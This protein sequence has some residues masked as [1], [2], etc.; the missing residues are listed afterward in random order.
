MDARISSKSL[1]KTKRHKLSVA[2][3]GKNILVNNL[4]NWVRHNYLLKH[5]GGNGLFIHFVRVEINVRGHA[6]LGK[7]SV[8]SG[9]FAEVRPD[10]SLPSR[11]F[12]PIN[13]SMIGSDGGAKTQGRI[14][15][16]CVL[17]KVRA[18]M[19]AKSFYRSSRKFYQLFKIVI[20]AMIYF[21]VWKHCNYSDPE[22]GQML[23]KRK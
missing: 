18:R 14:I 7:L 16:L 11:L 21:L 20:T 6:V 17:M 10:L 4:E 1:L 23:A 15:G 19:K 8:N 22:S 13:Q 3:T 9:S 5:R 12:S 2:S